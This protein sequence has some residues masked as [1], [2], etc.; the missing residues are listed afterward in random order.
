M[1]TQRFSARLLLSLSLCCAAS[2]L[3]VAFLL[4]ASAQT[5]PNLDAWIVRSFFEGDSTLRF[6]FEF[7]LWVGGSVL[8]LGSSLIGF[9]FLS[10]EMRERSFVRLFGLLLGSSGVLSLGWLALLILDAWRKGEFV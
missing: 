7:V 3:A 4:Q 1:D 2:G 10:P 9:F 5:L 6:T 8:A